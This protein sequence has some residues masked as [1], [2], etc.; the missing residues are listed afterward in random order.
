MLVDLISNC[1]NTGD[2]CSFGNT[3]LS[4]GTGSQSGPTWILIQLQEA[5]AKAE[6]LMIAGVRLG[7]GSDEVCFTPPWV[8]F[9]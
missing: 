7:F 2:E 8:V 1:V 4:E 6:E 5:V 3:P 9:L